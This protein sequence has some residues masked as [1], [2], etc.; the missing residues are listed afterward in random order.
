[1]RVGDSDRRVGKAEKENRER[2]WKLTTVVEES[3]KMV[4]VRGCFET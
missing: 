2:R 1:M 4:A 3:E